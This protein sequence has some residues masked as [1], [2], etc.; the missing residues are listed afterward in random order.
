MLANPATNVTFRAAVDSD[1]LC[2]GVLATQVFLDTYATDG[3]RPSIAREVLGHFSPVAVS[4]LLSAPGTRFIVAERDGHMIGFAQLA[5]GSIHE[6]VPTRPAAELNRLYV[7]ERFA[8]SGVGTALLREAE[9]LAAAQGA[10]TLWLTGW[11]GNHR[12]LAFY[13]RRGYEDL[14]AAS[15]VF[16]SEQ[17]ETRVF[18][19]ALRSKNA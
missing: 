2:I 19:K 18:A 7:Q 6:L 1:A 12:A 10:V 4:G 17:Y 15:Y 16:E 8:G 13:A 5:L 3:I 14:G 11:A 9:A